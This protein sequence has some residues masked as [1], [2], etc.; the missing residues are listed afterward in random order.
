MECKLNQYVPQHKLKL[1][2]PKPKETKESIC[3]FTIKFTIWK[4]NCSII[5]GLILAPKTTTYNFNLGIDKLFYFN[6]DDRDLASTNEHLI[7]LFFKLVS[8]MYATT[9]YAT[10][11]PSQKIR[12]SI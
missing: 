12:S 9:P 11:E 6:M 5:V 8:L 7:S 10:L 2:H 1:N 4:P 3:Q